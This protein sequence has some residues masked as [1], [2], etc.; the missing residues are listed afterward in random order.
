MGGEPKKH[1]RHDAHNL[2]CEHTI[3]EPIV[4]LWASRLADSLA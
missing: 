2:L 4:I 3:S 1:E